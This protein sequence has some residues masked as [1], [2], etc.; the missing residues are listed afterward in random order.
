[1][2]LVSQ[3]AQEA[4]LDLAVQRRERDTQEFITEMEETGVTNLSV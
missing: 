1:M 4:L 2:S 3:R